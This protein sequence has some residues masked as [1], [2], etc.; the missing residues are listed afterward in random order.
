MHYQ[1]STQSWT[2]YELP[3]EYKLARIQFRDAHTDLSYP[4]AVMLGDPYPPN[5]DKV[6]VV[7]PKKNP[8]GTLT[9]PRATVLDDNAFHQGGGYGAN[10]AVSAQDKT[11][12]V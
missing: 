9:I 5:G 4:P 1:A 12:I 11:W 10:F 6:A 3:E 8:D 2:P 7:F